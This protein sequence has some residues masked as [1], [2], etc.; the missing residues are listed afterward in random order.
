MRITGLLGVCAVA[1]CCVATLTLNAAEETS[2]ESHWYFAPGAGVIQ[3]EGDEEVKD[4]F[5]LTARLGYDYNEWWSLEGVF[6]LAPSL[7]ENFVGR[8]YD[9]ERGVAIDPPQ[10]VSQVT[11]TEEAAFGDTWAAGLAV[12]G[13]FHFTRWDRLDPYL[14]LGVGFLWY[15]DEVNEHT[16]DPALRGGGGVMYHFND[17]WAVRVDGRTFLAG[18]DTEANAVI[19][20]GVVWTWGARVPPKLVAIGGPNDSDG[21]GL[22]DDEELELGTDPYD[23]DTDSD[24]LSD[25]EEVNTYETNP[26]QP[27][28]DW[29]LLRD[30]PEVKT[31]GTDPLVADTDKG[32]VSDGHEVLED[33][34][35]P[36]VKAD[37]LMLFELN[38]QFDYDK[39]V[40]KPEFFAE[41]DVIGKV[42]TRHPESTA[43]IEGHADRKKDSSASYNRK[44]SERRAKAVLGYLA[45]TAG[46]KKNRMKA[47]G[48]GFDRPKA[49]NDPKLGNPVNRRVE[50]YIR[51]A[52]QLV[53]VAETTEAEVVVMDAA[54]K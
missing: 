45:E 2:L 54:D 14:S 34:T 36:R 16:F 43:L 30:G 48:Y 12:D 19:D 47:V 52:G 29:D 31:Y 26:L 20:A 18:N 3:Y 8:A 24:G 33:D 32:G 44:L 1:A 11:G 41:L 4:G 38:I 17:E 28:T 5:F 10:R 46:I 25:G 37:D 49:P 27:D 53:E 39:A 7:D 15:G 42:L 50:V 21:D 9:E 51:G 40:I 35:D 22:T 23:P 6:T 13:L